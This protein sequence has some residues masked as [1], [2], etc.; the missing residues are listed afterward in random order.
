M[1][2]YRLITLAVAGAMGLTAMTIGTPQTAFRHLYS[3]NPTGTVEVQNFYGDVS[4][5][6]WDRD[7]VLVEAVKKSS[8]PTRLEEA[9]IIVDSS[10]NSLSVRTQYAEDGDGNPASVEYRIMVPRAV[11]LQNVKLTNGGLSLCGLA[12]W[13]RAS[14]V[15][16]GIRAER[17][18]GRAELST[19]NG[20]LDADFKRIAGSGTISLSSVNGAIRLSLPAE[21]AA[22][23]A[24]R[25]LSGG[26]D[27][28]I[29]HSWRESSGNHL[30][31]VLNRGGVQIHLRNV[32]G[33]I[34][35]RSNWNRHNELPWS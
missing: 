25:N 26:I 28:D 1:S 11:N 33:G 20:R 29:G 15:N 21:A 23:L 18:E 7:E 12:G 31:A 22:S 32:N 10:Y 16:G 19:I 34:F 30:R 14:S 13:I 27:S 5:V 9:Q 6:A 35:I 3:L 24:A 2:I 4:I 17:L 8:D